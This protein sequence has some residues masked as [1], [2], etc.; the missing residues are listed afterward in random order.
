MDLLFSTCLNQICDVKVFVCCMGMGREIG[1]VCA[2]I[3]CKPT[4]I[5]FVAFE[6]RAC[7]MTFGNGNPIFSNVCSFGFSLLVPSILLLFKLKQTSLQLFYVKSDYSADICLLFVKLFD[8]K[9]KKTVLVSWIRLHRAGKNFI[10]DTL[11]TNFAHEFMVKLISVIYFTV[12]T[13]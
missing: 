2:T 8:A 3:Y 5:Y 6:L 4:K 12:Y 13:V 11:E 1:F 10:N 9:Y 7:I